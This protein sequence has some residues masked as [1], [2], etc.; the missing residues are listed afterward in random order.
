MT[1]DERVR[2]ICD[3]TET[4]QPIFAGYTLEVRGAA[5]A[6]LVSMWLTDHQCAGGPQ[7]EA[8]MREAVLKTLVDRVLALIPINEDLQNDDEGR[9]HH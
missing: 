6:D 9:K 5:L 3:L 7:K 1:D 2:Q 8:E 4:I